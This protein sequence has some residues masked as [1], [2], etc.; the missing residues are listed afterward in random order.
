MK[1]RTSNRWK[2][3]PGTYNYL[4]DEYLFEST[5]KL[6]MPSI[7]SLPQTD[8][9]TK[10]WLPF[11]IHKWGSTK[12][13]H[14][15]TDDHF[16]NRFWKKPQ[17]YINKLSGLPAVTT[18]DFSPYSDYPEAL[19]IY[20]I[21]RSRY[22]TR[23]MQESGLNVIPYINFNCENTWE[24][25]FDGVPKGLILAVSVVGRQ[26]LDFIKVLIDTLQPR[27]L[28]CHGDK[29]C[30]TI[31][32]WHDNVTFMLTHMQQKGLHKVKAGF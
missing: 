15:F 10:D 7:L 32:S 21:Y 24:Y 25:A 1:T 17:L 26:H 3:R 30:D 22:L 2:C 28:Y 5:C 8:P 31:L 12:P 29:N 20:Q 9:Q 13:V 14:F 16:Q 6:G 19:Q 23:M 18:P 27:K 4:N 11:H